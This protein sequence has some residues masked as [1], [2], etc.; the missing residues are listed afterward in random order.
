MGGWGGTETTQLAGVL[1][2][3]NAPGGAWGWV[4][5]RHRAR[6]KENTHRK[7]QEGEGQCPPSPTCKMQDAPRSKLGP[8][9]MCADHRGRTQSGWTCGLAKG[10]VVTPFKAK[11][12]VADD[13]QTNPVIS[14]HWLKSTEQNPACFLP[15]SLASWLS[16]LYPS[17]FIHAW[18][19]ISPC[20][21]LSP[22]TSP[23]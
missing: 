1:S 12:F 20:W 13:I 23:S 3:C 6:R 21:T 17:P 19:L 16:G 22:T 7:P 9:P 14:L 15:P 18:G 4:R 5:G 2:G 11:L 8:I 10:K